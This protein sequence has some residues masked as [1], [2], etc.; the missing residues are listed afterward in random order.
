MQH[1]EVQGETGGA[2]NQQRASSYEE[3]KSNTARNS[4][5]KIYISLQA[6]LSA[7]R[8]VLDVKSAYLKSRIGQGREALH[9][10]TRR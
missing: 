10:I 8:M 1:W 2:G 4:S 5:V 9:S 6:K 7:K 3:I